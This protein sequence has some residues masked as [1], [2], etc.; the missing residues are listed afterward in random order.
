MYLVKVWFELEEQTL[1]HYP[2][3]EASVDTTDIEVLGELLQGWR[4]AG[5]WKPVAE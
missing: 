5:M 2:L 3:L 4:K 1:P